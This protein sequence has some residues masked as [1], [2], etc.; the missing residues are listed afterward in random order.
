M[1][2]ELASPMDRMRV[3]SLL[4]Q[5]CLLAIVLRGAYLAR[6]PI[7]V[8]RSHG[9][10][11]NVASMAL[12]T[13]VPDWKQLSNTGVKLNYLMR[14]AQYLQRDRLSIYSAETYSH[15]GKPLESMFQLVSPHQCMGVVESVTSIADAEPQ[16]LRITGW[17][18]DLRG[19]RAPR[20]M[21]ATTDGIITGLAALGD[22]RPAVRAGNP[23]ITSSYIG[24]A[25]YVR[26]G[27][28]ET[29]VKIYAL[30][31]GNQ[32]SACYITTIGLPAR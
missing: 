2:L 26:D 30:L 31:H 15:L 14:E 8:A 23:G 7:R 19:R 3:S 5:V 16:A 4:V 32:R 13:G 17:A 11:L 24:F 18:W 9:F 22:W 6:Y 12:L 21:I 29:P 10:Q 20:E 25:G 28:K 1:L 27:K